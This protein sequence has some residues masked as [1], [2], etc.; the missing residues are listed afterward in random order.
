M[1]KPIKDTTKQMEELEKII[2]NEAQRRCFKERTACI[3]WDGWSYGEKEK[4]VKIVKKDF[5]TKEVIFL[6]AT[7]KKRLL[8]EIE[9]FEQKLN[10]YEIMS[11]GIDDNN[12]MLKELIKDGRKLLS[13][14]K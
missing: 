11:D 14:M 5:F 8:Q 10:R 2:E 13:S 6:F 4:W 3:F 7:E 12:K 1:L 9:E